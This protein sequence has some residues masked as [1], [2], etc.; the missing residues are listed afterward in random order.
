M[1]SFQSHS[2]NKENEQ[3][4]AGKTQE[5]EYEVDPETD[6][7]SLVSFKGFDRPMGNDWVL[8]F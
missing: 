6:R 4:R 1:V 8:W 3:V 5:K 7:N 2:Q